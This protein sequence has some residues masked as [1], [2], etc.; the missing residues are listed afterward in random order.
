M[1]NHTDLQD[2]YCDHCYDIYRIQSQYKGNHKRGGPARGR[3]TFAVAANGRHICTLALNSANAIAMTTILVLHV[4][5]IGHDVPC[6]YDLM[7]LRRSFHAR[8]RAQEGL[9]R[10]VIFCLPDFYLIK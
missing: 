3:A 8:L 6:H 4:G 10:L 7:F 9:R 2:K 1:S 5:V